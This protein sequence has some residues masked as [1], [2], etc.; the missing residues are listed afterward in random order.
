MS[1]GSFLRMHPSPPPL[2]RTHTRSLSLSL[3]ANR[4]EGASSV[5]PFDASIHPSDQPVLAILQRARKKR[6]PELA[7]CCMWLNCEGDVKRT[8]LFDTRRLGCPTRLSL[9]AHSIRARPESVALSPRPSNE[10]RR[11]PAAPLLGACRSPSLPLSPSPPSP[12]LSLSPSLLP[13]K[14][15]TPL[16]SPRSLANKERRA[17]VAFFHPLTNTRHAQGIP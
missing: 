14:S 13:P 5:R 11:C 2:R 3:Q 16:E 17:S 4:S 12:P 8:I 6:A 10:G 1:C 9:L 7:I 15:V